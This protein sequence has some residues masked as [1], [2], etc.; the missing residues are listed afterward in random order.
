MRKF[1]IVL[2]AAALLLPLAPA[3]AQPGA[4]QD[5]QISGPETLRQAVAELRANMLRAGERVDG[6]DVGGANPDADLRAA[7]AESHYFLNSGDD[8]ASVGIITDRPL[9]DF[10]PEGWRVIDSYGSS[11]VRL[12]GAQLDFVPLSARYIFASRTRFRRRGDIDCTSGIANALLYEVPD[13]AAGPNDE[14][15]PILF[16]LMIL[17][18]EDQELCVRTDGDRARGYRSRVF[19]P[20]GRLLPEMTDD[21]G[22]TTIVPAAPIDR[23]IVP[24]PA[25]P[26]T[27]G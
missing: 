9:T 17:A 5:L 19:L 11:A 12:P 4:E 26:A 1:H 3:T 14:S 8:G 22:I 27:V 6:W 2:T 13:A 23:L 16:R 25:G 20:D 21:D 18:T 7:G 24:P 10:A 15:I